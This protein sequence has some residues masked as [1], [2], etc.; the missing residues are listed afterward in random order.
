MSPT[1][2]Y[3]VSTSRPSA[4]STPSRPT[5]GTK[6]GRRVARPSTVRWS[7]LSRDARRDGTVDG[8]AVDGGRTVSQQRALRRVRSVQQRINVV[9]TSV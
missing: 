7:S 3:R 9:R 4:P 5:D 1:P 6:A 8:A 2:Q